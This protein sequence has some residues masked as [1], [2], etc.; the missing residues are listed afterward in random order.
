MTMR[1]KT[2]PDADQAIAV[3]IVATTRT[4]FVRCFI[5]IPYQILMAGC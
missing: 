5:L 3:G 1:L 4:R 2:V